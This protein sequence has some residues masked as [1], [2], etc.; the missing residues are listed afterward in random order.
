[1]SAPALV[2]SGTADGEGGGAYVVR[3]TLR[4]TGAPGGSRA[5]PLLWPGNIT[6]DADLVQD[7]V[8]HAVGSSPSVREAHVT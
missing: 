1:M 3:R 7:D 8:E 5:R 2:A 4:Q 6:D